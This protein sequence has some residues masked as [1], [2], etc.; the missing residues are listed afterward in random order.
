MQNT[1]KIDHHEN[2]T[3]ETHMTIR[4]FKLSAKSDTIQK[5]F[6]HIFPKNIFAK[7]YLPGLNNHKFRHC[8]NICINLNRG[9]W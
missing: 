1:I 2:L 4:L 5:T 8:Y 6:T 7:K 3:G 9:E